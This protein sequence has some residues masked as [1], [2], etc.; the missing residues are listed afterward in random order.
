MAVP[1]RTKVITWV[2]SYS[3]KC[4]R[5]KL[6]NKIPE[7]ADLFFY[8]IL[9]TSQ[10]LTKTKSSIHPAPSPKPISI[11]LPVLKGQERMSRSSSINLSLKYLLKPTKIDGK[12]FSDFNRLKSEPSADMIQLEHT[13]S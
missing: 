12:T 4:T 6:W 13:P 9:T 3:L 1:G 8:P 5:L 11:F 2:Q 7:I 10:P